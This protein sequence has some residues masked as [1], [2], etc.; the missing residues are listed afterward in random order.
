[1]FTKFPIK[2]HN[3]YFYYAIHIDIITNKIY[4][5]KY[6][7]YNNKNTDFVKESNVG[8]KKKTFFI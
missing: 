5:N 8:L 7:I 4:R 3:M 6:K 1:M 2:R